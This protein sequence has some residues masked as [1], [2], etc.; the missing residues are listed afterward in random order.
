MVSASSASF[1]CIGS[2]AT[3]GLLRICRARLAY[4]SVLSVSSR[5]ASPGDT[6]ASIIV[7]ELPPSES[8]RRR[9]S[10]ESRYGTWWCFSHRALITLP[11]AS[12]PLLIWMPSCSRSPL[13]PVRLA[14]SE[15][16]RSTKCSFG[17]KTLPVLAKRSSRLMVKMACERELDAFIAVA[18]V[19]RFRAPSTRT[20]IAS[21]TLD[22]AR[23][24]CPVSVR[25]P[26]S[27]S[28]M[29]SVGQPPASV[30]V[31]SR[32]WTSSL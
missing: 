9:V 24:C 26:P 29:G 5:S 14:R 30:R 3:T 4:L 17:L 13:A 27:V 2:C 31:P 18:P 32:S 19:C 23:V 21:S 12:R 15:P 6:H 11:S 22:T 20:A 25:P 28:R 10:F 16:A 7:L 1:A 8:C